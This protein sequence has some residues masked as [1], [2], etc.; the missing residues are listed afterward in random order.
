[1]KLLPLDLLGARETSP[2]IV[3]FGCL[4][5]GVTASSGFSIEV[6]V[7]H[8][9]DQF[10]QDIE[11]VG[12]RLEHR[13]PS[14][15]GLEEYDYWYGRLEFESRADTPNWGCH[16]AY[17]YRL[18]ITRPDGH[19]LDGMTDAFARQ[20]G[21][22]DLSAFELGYRDHRWRTPE[23][24]WE[25]PEIRDLIVY[26][27]MLSEFA[28]DIDGAYHR[29][30][31][32]SDLGV[33][34]LEIMPVCNVRSTIDWGYSPLGYFGVD[35]RFGNR[36]T[37]QKF[38][39]EA[40][41]RGMAVILDMVYG[42]TDI[43][44]PYVHG[45]VN[46]AGTYF[47]GWY[48]RLGLPSPYGH[49]HGPWGPQIDMSKPL[50]QDLL[51]TSN[52]H[53]LHHYRVDGFRYDAIQ[54][55]YDGPTGEGYANLVYRTFQEVK[56]RSSCEVPGPWCRFGKDA[57]RLIQMAEYL[58]DQGRRSEDI[59]FGTYTN[60]VWQDRSLWPARRVARQEPGSLTDYGLG[61]GGESFPA[62]VTHNEADTLEKAPV[63]YIENHDHER[64]ICSYGINPRDDVL[65]QEGNRGH[66][67]KLQPHLIALLTSKGIPLLWMGQEVGENY[68]VPPEGF[69][70]VMLLRPIRWDYFY[71]LA[72]RPLID[73]TR[74]L[75]R[76]RRASPQFSRG[77]HCFYDEP[78]RYQDRGLLLF[79]RW[80]EGGAFTLVALNFT[81]SDQTVD[82]AFPQPG[83]YHD[84]LTG[85]VLSV[86]EGPTTFI[87]PSNFGRLW[88]LP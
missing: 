75:L 79:S 70:R 78:A 65:L 26:E 44:F 68:Y 14:P 64:L 25:T 51:L 63:Q 16:G 13:V 83:E 11:P 45:L 52:L 71:D 24:A 61:L 37:F 67:Y 49:D 7:I 41:R 66:W 33:N 10:D 21:V 40:H 77:D 88:T 36:R 56:A 69:G 86:M 42:H 54:Q 29:L 32:L 3:E 62:V 81:D 76:L 15:P 47:E 2:G 34:C 35:E 60:A 43:R 48:G 12:V 1:M 27:L 22:A 9:R 53:W 84:G 20:Y 30:D 87:I 4:V 74:K 31:Y 23:E 38:V 28:G 73:L 50:A 39:D 85:D 19:V 58:D 55:Y 57:S 5:P 82:L 6:L 17:V 46:Q 59:L 8:S 18:R 72:G 80:I